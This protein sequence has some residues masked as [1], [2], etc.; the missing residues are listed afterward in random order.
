[1]TKKIDNLQEETN[2]LKTNFDKIKYASEGLSKLAKEK[3]QNV[4]KY[5]AE[6]LIM[7]CKMEYL[8]NVREFLNSGQIDV[9]Y[10]DEYGK[11]A[12]SYAYETRN[13]DLIY[14]LTKAG[15]VKL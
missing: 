13:L 2:R 9:K 8:E 15:F 3:N 14:E 7:C 5:M 4:N 11:N 6:C 1:M 12:L 10:I